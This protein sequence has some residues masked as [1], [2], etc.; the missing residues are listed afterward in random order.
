[1]FDESLSLLY[2][3]YE[4]DKDGMVLFERNHPYVIIGRLLFILSI[5]YFF[6]QFNLLRSHFYNLMGLSK[7]TV[8]QSWNEL[9]PRVIKFLT[10]E[11]NKSKTAEVS[12]SIRNVLKKYESVSEKSCET[13]F[14]AVVLGLAAKLDLRESH[15][16]LHF[17]ASYFLFYS[18]YVTVHS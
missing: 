3:A 18:N 2:A 16:L 12:K 7:E 17:S 1:M 11:G 13:E 8:E 4:S 15:L 14:V 10:A 6:L 5:F 9:F